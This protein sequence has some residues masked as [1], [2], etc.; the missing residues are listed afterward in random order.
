MGNEDLITLTA[1]IVAAHVSNNN[2]PISDVSTLVERV[3]GALASL[4]TGAAPAEE[5]K[6]TPVVSPRS[7]IKP[8]Y[9]TCLECGRKQRTL[10]RHLMTAHKLTPD[11]YRSDYGL[12]A[13]YP[14]AAPDY[15][16]MRRDMAKKIGLG[17]KR[18]AA[19]PAK[20]KAESGAARRPRGRPRAAAKS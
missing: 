5:A 3:H 18:G 12:S 17:R 11:Q 19:A 4:G 6:K 20:A 7:S 16:E 8:D 9:L 15:A 10:K 1:D 2:V 14:M 13:T